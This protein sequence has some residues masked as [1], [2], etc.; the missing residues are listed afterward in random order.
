MLSSRKLWRQGRHKD[1]IKPHESN[2]CSWLEYS[3][4]VGKLR[5]CY[6]WWISMEFPN[7]AKPSTVAY[8]ILNFLKHITIHYHIENALCCE[9]GDKNWIWISLNFCLSAC[10]LA[11]LWQKFFLSHF[12][13]VEPAIKRIP[14]SKHHILYFEYL[15]WMYAKMQKIPAYQ[16]KYSIT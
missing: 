11:L 13:I 14:T 12:L 3:N 7:H 5:R 10:L 8:I 15:F 9:L 4:N 2:H 1:A 16:M 6:L